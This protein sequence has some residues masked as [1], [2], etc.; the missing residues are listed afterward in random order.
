MKS[1][2]LFALLICLF[3]ISGSSAQTENNFLINLCQRWQLTTIEIKETGKKYPPGEKR[4]RNF[5]QFKPDGTFKSMED[6]KTINGKWRV[7]EI[8]M[9]LFTYDFDDQQLT[10]SI[11]FSI[12][13][14]TNSQLA[15]TT[16][17][18]SDKQVIMHYSVAKSNTKKKR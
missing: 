10:S 7:D 16:L 5:F 6:G 12:V 2:L 4:I 13:A 18:V 9:E 1:T 17:P 15:I 11:T 8:K 14:L 3:N